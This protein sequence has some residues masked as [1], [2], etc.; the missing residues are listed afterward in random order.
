MTSRTTPRRHWRGALVALVAAVA[1]SSTL[2]GPL[3]ARAGEP[4]DTDTGLIGRWK[5]DET[6]GTVAAD[7]SGNGRNGTVT[8]T[9][10]WNSGDGFTFTGGSNSSGNAIK[11]PDNLL[12]GA[13]DLTVDFDV[14]VDPTLSGNW[15][16]YNLGNSATYPN[17]TGYLFTTNDSSGRYRSTIAEAGFASE[18]STSRSTKL[19][20]GA[21]K[22]VTYTID[23]GA[24]GAPGTARLYE[25][26]VLVATNANVTTS[27]GLLGTPDGT[28]TLNQLGR[29][30]YSGDLSFKGKLRDFRLYSR[31]LTADESAELAA[32]AVAPA[33]DADAAAL[34]LGDTSAVVTNLALPAT[35]ASSTTSIAWSSSDPATVGNTGVVVRPAHGSAPATATL[36]ATLTRG[37]GTRVRTFDVTV[38]PEELDDEGK[39]QA[40]VAAVQLV[41]PDD[42]R[43]NLALPSS[44]PDDTALTWSSS[45]PEV[46]SATGEVTRPAH[47]AAAVDVTLT[48]TGT[49]GTATASRD[50]VVRVQPAPAAPD[51]E[52][53]AF[54]YFAG[55]STDDGEK[56]HLGAS[57]GNDPLA[58][59]ALN[60]GAPVLSSAFGEQGLRDPF[61]IRSHEGDR[62]FLLATDLKAYPAVDFGQAQ[63]SGSKYIEVWESTDLVHWS[64]QRHIK[65][66]SDFAGNTW[67]PESFYDEEAGEYVVYWASA[68][69]PTTDVAGRDI[70]TQYQQMLY[71]T[72]RDFV[73]FSDPQPWI[74]VKRGTGRGMIDA[75]VVK[76]GDTFY[77][78]VKDEASMTPRQ[79]RSTDLRATVSGS[80][81]TT[82]SAPGWQL[83]KERVGVGQPNPW[84]GTFTNGEGPTVFRDNEDPDRWYL[85]IDQPS[86]HG[87]Q[88]YLAF[89]TEDIASGS[90]TSVPTADLPSSP[91]H[92]TVIPV[93]QAELDALRGGF[94]PELLI[95]DVS[96][97]AVTTRAGTAPNLPGTVAASLGDGSSGQVAVTWDDIDPTSYDGAGTFTVTGTV[98]RGSSDRPVATVTV[99]DAED[100][101]VTI[102]SAA[103]GAQDWWVTSP[104]SATVSATD[105]TGV[106]RVE[107]SVDGGAWVPAAGDTATLVVEGEGAHEVRARAHDVTGN[108]STVVTGRV[109]IDTE[110]PVSRATV[111]ADRTVGVRAADAGSGVERVEYRLDGADWTSY[112]GPVGVGDAAVDVEYRAV[113]RAGTVEDTNTLVVP[114]VGDALVPTAVTAVAGDTTVRRGTHVPISVRVTAP[115]G[116]PT[117]S[118]RAI[119]G[120]KV[121]ASANLANGRARI[122]IDTE[123]IAGVGLKDVVIRYDGDATHRA[124]ED[125]VTLR[126]SAA[127]SATSLRV[128]AP[129]RAGR[130][131]VARVR[132]VTDPAGVDVPGIRLVLRRDGRVVRRVTLALDSSGRGAWRLPRLRPGRWTVQ[133]T[134]VGTALLGGSTAVQ[135]LRV[136]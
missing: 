49:K 21:W 111:G 129:D 114:A 2:A 125:V 110:A 30:A 130:H 60:D 88:G 69:Y 27:P 57:Q 70:N 96:D 3:P 94:Q 1:A 82:T 8:G 53:Y 113:D 67:A 46:V 6:S 99:T 119:A 100:P 58:Y 15:F 25:D 89:T 124:A 22:H 51:Y 135:G 4:V 12:A 40:A 103:D 7:S 45:T 117:G 16:M 112:D 109:R 133:A 68:L 18:Q 86:Y 28:T 118:V 5:L 65:V 104:A 14:W 20:A 97:V 90:W 41:H 23:G 120:G 13:D 87:G 134:V 78:V 107:T 122:V 98:S 108:V 101:V 54:A 75:T 36:T 77:R 127:R 64:D 39:A 128:I 83:V 37:T 47:G 38:S 17:G 95:E 50:I 66:S 91:R 72:T 44:G 35:G 79:E 19:Q 73:T 59:D 92:G 74:D 123:R 33:L 9:A 56:I 62:F 31:V 93:T 84:G 10:S 115:D 48:V 132:V 126:L 34:T 80:L 81:P 26:G 63:E 106:E 85:F 105:D 102:A 43:G 42:V 32:D 29:S 131:A 11:L 116:V 55:E 24:V 71:A 136:R 61:I 76:D 121:L 52:G